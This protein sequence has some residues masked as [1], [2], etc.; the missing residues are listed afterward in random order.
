M[1]LIKTLTDL[2]LLTFLLRIILQATRA[3][4]YNP[5]SQFIV[6]VTNPLVVP[7]RRLLPSVRQ[8]DLPTLAVLVVLQLIVTYVLVLLVGLNVRADQLIVLAA[9]RLVQ[10]VLWTYTICIFV[11]VILSWVAQA[12]Y[13]PIAM[14]LGQIVAPVLRPFRR[15]VPLVGGF[16]L[17]PLFALILIQA[18]SLLL[19]ASIAPSVLS[20][21]LASL[22]R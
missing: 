19:A 1:F 6:A 13:S 15:I 3:D 4:F 18:A 16:D 14:L 10:L 12:S 7:A 20:P 21:V 22:V 17:S 5:I 9:F 2:Y 11:Y 8:I